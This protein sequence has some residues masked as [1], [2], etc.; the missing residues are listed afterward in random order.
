MET[1]KDLRLELMDWKYP[2]DTLMVD[3]YPKG[4]PGSSDI[5]LAE[6]PHVSI[7][8][9][10]RTDSAGSTAWI[11]IDVESAVKLRDLLTT[12]LLEA[13]RG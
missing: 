2:K 4:M 13:G 9:M 7:Q 12:F 11:E 8:A 1:S 3:T 6:D 5:D 10:E